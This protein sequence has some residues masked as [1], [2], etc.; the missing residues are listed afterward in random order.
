VYYTRNKWKQTNASVTINGVT[1]EP[2]KEVKY[3]KI[4]FDQE[5]RFKSHI[6][7]ECRNDTDQYHKMYLENLIHAS[8]TNLPSSRSTPHELCGHSVTPIK[9]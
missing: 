8:M 1:I 2:T 6:Q 9:G 3:L 4:I 5:L 7:H